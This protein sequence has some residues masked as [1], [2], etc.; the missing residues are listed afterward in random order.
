VR[1]NNFSQVEKVSR[2]ETQ[3]KKK[4]R[5]NRW[6]ENREGFQTVT[7]VGEARWTAHVVGK[8]EDDSG[9]GG[10]A[11]DARLAAAATETL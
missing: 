4:C 8:A 3:K 10:G 2:R 7:S 9:G 5:R 6:D 1:H 11:Q